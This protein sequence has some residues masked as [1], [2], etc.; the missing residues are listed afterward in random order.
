MKRT[1]LIISILVLIIATTGCEQRLLGEGGNLTGEIVTGTT[2]GLVGEQG[3]KENST[4]GN[5][6]ALSIKPTQEMINKQYTITKTEGDLIILAPKA[7]DPDGDPVSYTFS[8]PFDKEGRWQT[9]YG[10]E[11][12]YKVIITASDPKGAKTRAEILVKVLHAN[13]RPQLDCP[14]ELNVREGEVIDLK[15]KVSDA[16]EDPVTVTYNGW[17]TNSTYKTTYTDAGEHNVTITADDGKSKPVTKEVK[18]KVADVNR[19]PIFPIDFPKEV[20][21]QEGDIITLTTSEVIDPDGDPVTFIFSEPFDKNGVWKTKIGDAGEYP[22]DIVASDGKTSTKEHVTVHVK[23]INTAPVLKRI[24]DIVV[25]EGETIKLP[26]EATDRENDN[27]TY[28]ITGW[29]N[30]KEYTTTYDDAGTY[31]TKVRVS[32]GQLSDAQVVHI[33]VVDRNRPPVFKVPA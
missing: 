31:T 11:G 10:D 22:V 13:R 18:I 29:M 6:T 30:S 25:Y 9:S 3:A 24:P 27:L 5:E 1:I 32:D 16:E 8:K 26:L 20:V 12:N 4:N 19:A 21:A 23:M 17:M 2:V 28:T 33:T 15:C 14:E 7:V